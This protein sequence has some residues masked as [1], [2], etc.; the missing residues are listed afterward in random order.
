MALFKYKRL[1]E[2]DPRPGVRY[3]TVY[4][5]QTTEEHKRLQAWLTQVA[6]DILGILELDPDLA[7]WFSRPQVDFRK[8][9]RGE[10]Y[11]PEELLT[12]ML[13]QLSL[14]RDLP[15]AMLDRW[16][17]LTQGTAWQI[18]FEQENSVGNPVAPEYKASMW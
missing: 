10:Y 12:D 3:A 6:E 14:G 17:K 1:H 11:S 4:I 15:Q 5:K 9:R 8:S 7:Q 13:N 2:M 18:E 16:N